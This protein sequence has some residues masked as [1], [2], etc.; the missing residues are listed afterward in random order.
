MK[1]LISVWIAAAMMLSLFG[2]S[3]PTVS[4][5]GGE[6]ITSLK[7]YQIGSKPDDWEQVAA[8]FNEKAKADIGVTTEWEFIS[9]G[10]Y[11][12][13]LNVIMAAGQEFDVCFTGFAN[14]I[15]SAVNNGAFLA[16]DDLIEQHAPGLKE[17]M[18]AYWWEAATF[19]GEIYAV[20]NQQVA[21]MPSGIW[22]Y[23]SY[24]DKYGF[25]LG[26]IK[27]LKDI[28]PM[29]EIIKQNEPDK[30]AFR[31]VPNAGIGFV[32]GTS[33][34]YIKV[35]TG[36]YIK[37]DDEKAKLINYYEM[38]QYYEALKTYNDWWQK[39]Y[40]RKDIVSVMD[41]ASDFKAGKYIFNTGNWKPGVEAEMLA[42]YGQDCSFAIYNEGCVSTESCDSSMFA[43][44]RTSKHPAKAMEFI[45]YI[46]TNKEAYNMLASGLA[47]IHYDPL[48]DT[49]IHIKENCT[50]PTGSGWKW[51]NQ[52]NAYIT[53]AQEL[54]VWEE[55]K[56]LNEDADVSPLM[57]FRANTDLILTE[58][59]Q[60]ESV[61]SEFSSLQFSD[62]EKLYPEFISRLEGAGLSKI[63][64]EYQKQIDEFLKNK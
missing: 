54:D 45:N 60:V 4:D 25:D 18:P 26:S 27:C 62:Y 34:E 8:A 63:K 59:A 13:K 41:D 20:P 49:R 1:K 39:G 57:G 21:A 6:E 43:I 50:Y 10:A 33:D 12:E 16:L 64:D 53:D 15:A 47:G 5:E 19:D 3:K 35:T 48:D 38:P 46:N 9:A 51:G 23:K 17:T 24:A 52:F 61:I 32:D 55:T 56:K 58:I 7:I 44:S 2:C 31:A 42:S 11:T 22:L 14:P 28:E 30:W 37:K 29:L 40:I 36:L